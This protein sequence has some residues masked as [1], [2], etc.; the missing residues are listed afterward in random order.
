MAVPWVYAFQ[1]GDFVKVGV[2]RDIQR[3]LVQ[4]RALNPFEIRVLLQWR[5][6][7]A[8]R[9]E[10]LMHTLLDDAAIGR[11][12]F[13]VPPRAI[14]LAATIA[15]EHVA[16]WQAEQTAWEEHAPETDGRGARTWKPTKSVARQRLA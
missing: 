6:R 15:R 11:E 3:R 8:F 4:M 5:H 7:Y 1:C 16:Q 2:S 12:W 13:A 10:R 14:E 9:I